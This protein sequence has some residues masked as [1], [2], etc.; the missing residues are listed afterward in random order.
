LVVFLTETSNCVDYLA[1]DFIHFQKIEEGVCSLRVM[2]KK[3]MLHRL[4]RCYL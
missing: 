2:E 1:S 4:C 3:K